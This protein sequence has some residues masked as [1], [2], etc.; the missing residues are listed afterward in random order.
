[1]Q[2]PT[3][4]YNS[5]K[6]VPETYSI[7]ES[8]IQRTILACWTRILSSRRL[9]DL[10]NA[11]FSAWWSRSCSIMSWYSPMTL[12]AS[13]G[14]VLKEAKTQQKPNSYICDP[15][16]SPTPLYK[17]VEI[18][19]RGTNNIS[20]LYGFSVF[21]LMCDFSIALLEFMRGGTTKKKATAVVKLRKHVPANHHPSKEIK[22]LV[23]S[24]L[25]YAECC[26]TYVQRFQWWHL[27]IT[28]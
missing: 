17:I 23:C 28:D 16:C 2:S 22:D 11:S 14:C 8:L 10:R 21:S 18:V 4:I 12:Q 26:W 25:R 1:M 27:L 5:I 15:T 7:T 13:W 3:F 6:D 24:I 19:R 9:R 20:V